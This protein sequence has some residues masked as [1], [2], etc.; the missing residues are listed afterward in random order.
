MQRRNRNATRNAFQMRIFTILETNNLFIT[1]ISKYQDK[2]PKCRFLN[3]RE[4][5]IHTFMLLL[6]QFYYNIKHNR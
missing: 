4:T 2:T 3:L 6:I 1:S 5:F